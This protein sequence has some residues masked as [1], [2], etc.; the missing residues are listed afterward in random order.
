MSPFL[1]RYIPI[2][3]FA[4]L[5]LALLILGAIVVGRFLFNVSERR[6]KKRKAR[7]HGQLPADA[8]VRE[9]IAE[10]K[11]DEARELYQQFTGVDMFTAKE[12]IDEMAREFR[13]TMIDD[14]VL[15]TLSDEGKAAAIQRYQEDTGADFDAALKHVERLEKARK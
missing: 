9:L 14:D 15:M 1:L 13:L 10:G 4:L 8:G 5:L 7:K 3:L 6:A 11:L 2:I 12:A